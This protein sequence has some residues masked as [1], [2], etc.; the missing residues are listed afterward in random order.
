MKLLILSLLLTSCATPF[1]SQKRQ[2]CEK[3][4]IGCGYY[5]QACKIIDKDNEN[6]STHPTFS[7]HYLGMNFK[8]GFLFYSRFVLNT[9]YD[10]IL[11]KEYLTRN[12]TV[13]VGYIL[14][15]SI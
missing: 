7:D 3:G 8:L 9:T 14:P 5:Q 6:I 13:N 12:F 10:I 2:T 4:Q 15:L 11:S 1:C